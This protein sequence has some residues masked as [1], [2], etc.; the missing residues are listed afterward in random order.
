MNRS[1]DNS[2]PDPAREETPRGAGAGQKPPVPHEI[3]ESVNKAAPM[4]RPELEQATAVTMQANVVPSGVKP[5]SV[6]SA[7]VRNTN[8]SVVNVDKPS[9]LAAPDPK[10]KAGANVLQQY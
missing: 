3:Y 4:P 10:K 2:M 8:I 7:E 5:I 1:N 9:L 6:A